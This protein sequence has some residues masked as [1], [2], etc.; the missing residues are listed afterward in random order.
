MI[1]Y[2]W[3]LFVCL[4]NTIQYQL[5]ISNI[6]HKFI[7]T[8]QNRL[9]AAKQQLCYLWW[10]RCCILARNSILPLLSMWLLKY[11]KL[12][13]QRVTLT[14]LFSDWILQCLINDTQTKTNCF[15]LSQSIINSWVTPLLTPSQVHPKLSS[16]QLASQ[17]PLQ[18]D[19]S[20]LSSLSW[21]FISD[22]HT[23]HCHRITLH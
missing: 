6:K 11:V 4:G 16:L 10:H 2:I 15:S 19:L 17:A 14:I 8:P 7:W 13:V 22:V 3:Q 12:F 1:W 23:S 5:S 21:E 20:I 18:L 9:T